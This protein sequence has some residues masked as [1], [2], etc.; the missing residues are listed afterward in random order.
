MVSDVV[1]RFCRADL[2]VCLSSQTLVIG[3]CEDLACRSLV[4]SFG[5]SPLRRFGFHNHTLS[6]SRKSGPVALA[7]YLHLLGSHSN[8]F[9]SQMMHFLHPCLEFL[10][11]LLR[12]QGCIWW[13]AEQKICRQTKITSEEHLGWG[14]ACG[15]VNG[16]PVGKQEKG[17][18]LVPVLLI[19]G[20]QEREAVQDGPI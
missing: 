7:S 2:T 9:P 8:S 5:E 12:H 14:I 6:P 16:T 20:Y 19:T 10:D 1:V 18:L 3:G 17:Q 4:C 15:L 11:I 13:P